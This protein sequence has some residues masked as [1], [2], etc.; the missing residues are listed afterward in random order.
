MKKNNAINNGLIVIISQAFYGNRTFTEIRPND[1]D[2]FLCGYLSDLGEEINPD[3]KVLVKVPGTD[4]LVIIYNRDEEAETIERDWKDEYK[5]KPLA[6]I[7][8]LDL[9]IYS[10]CIVCRISADGEFESLQAEDWEKYA[11]YLAE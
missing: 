11:K 3:A 8:E 7:P 1:I 4:N 10:R 9:K 6:G 5:R 2:R